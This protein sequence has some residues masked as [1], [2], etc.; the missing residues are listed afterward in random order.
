MMID[1]HCHLNDRKGFPDPAIAIRQAV[2]AGVEKIVVVG[3]DRDWSEKAV[4]LAEAHEEVF[5]VVGWHPTSA[6]KY[7]REELAIIRDLA[8]HP[9]VVAIGEIGFDFY[10][11][12]S[13]L[14][15]QT[16]CLCDQLDL[17]EEL[18][19][20]VVF[21][22][23]EAYPALLDVLEKRPIRPYLLHCFAGNLDDAKR[24][25]ALDCT[26][27]VD[28]P[29]TYKKADDLRECMRF[30]G[31]DRIVLET[32]AP[33][34]SPVPYRGK[35]NHPAYLGYIRDGLASCLDL[36]QDEVAKKTTDNARRFYRLP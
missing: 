4:A 33:W 27:G 36:S 18:D 15:Q 17:A 3:I 11:D 10:W 23:R 22:C 12:Y 29:V 32:D 25:I 19:L 1:T 9:K 6:A 13:T 28:G 30:I 35:P 31:I 8:A 16:V 2:E 20:P 24:A 14:E 21:H 5:A 7:N 26:F 34:L